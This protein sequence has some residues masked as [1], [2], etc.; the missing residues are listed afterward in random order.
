MCTFNGQ[1]SRERYDVRRDLSRRLSPCQSVVFGDENREDTRLD[2]TRC[3][4]Q[5]TLH[6]AEGCLAVPV[7]APALEQ[8]ERQGEV[9]LRARRLLLDRLG[10]AL[11]CLSV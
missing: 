5:V 1:L 3:R 11:R 4:M 8:R 10:E 9:R 2:K 7:R 6:P